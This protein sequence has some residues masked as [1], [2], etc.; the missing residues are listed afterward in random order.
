MVTGLR[1]Q[2][3][4]GLIELVLYCKRLHLLVVMLLRGLQDFAGFA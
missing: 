4:R 2:V 3:L 1:E